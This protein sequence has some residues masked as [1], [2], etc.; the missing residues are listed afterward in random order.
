[1]AAEVSAE[2]NI[3]NKYQLSVKERIILS[4]MK[5]CLNLTFSSLSVFLGCTVKIASNIFATIVPILASIFGTFIQ[6]P[7]KEEVVA[8]CSKNFR[9]FQNVRVVLDC[10]E[11]LVQKSK[12]LSECI[13]LYSHYYKDLTI[14]YLIAATP[15]GLITFFSKGY[16]GK[17][18]D[19]FIFLQNNIIEMLEP[20]IDAVMT[21][22][23]FLINEICDKSF[24]KL[25]R[26]PFL[27]S[28][29]QFSQEEAISS[30]KTARVRVQIERTIQR[31]KIFGILKSRIPYHLLN[32]IDHIIIIAAGITNLSIPILSDD[33]FA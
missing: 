25:I 9:T 29:K 2:L 3:N 22:K 15:A 12:C 31:I 26:P 4:M 27:R 28:K 17:A 33:K 6:W 13:A 32:L 21:D 30:Q 7:V 5:I 1:M 8:N 19:K 14:K 16:G 23:G 20:H 11:I 10:T 18:S 24:I